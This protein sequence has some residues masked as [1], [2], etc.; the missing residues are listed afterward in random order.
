MFRFQHF[1][2]M[3][4]AHEGT[5]SGSSRLSGSLSL[6]HKYQLR[7]VDNLLPDWLTLDWNQQDLLS[8]NILLAMFE[9]FV[10]LEILHSEDEEIPKFDPQ[11]WRCRSQIGSNRYNFDNYEVQ[12]LYHELDEGNKKYVDPCFMIQ[13]CSWREWNRRARPSCYEI[14]ILEKQESTSTHQGPYMSGLPEGAWIN[15]GWKQWSHQQIGMLSWGVW[16]LSRCF[17]ELKLN[18]FGRSLDLFQELLY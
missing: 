15:C 4:R 9:W 3:I 13:L 18:R 12:K 2:R 7:R 11:I 16:K 10:V 6:S 17:L 1:R 8:Y 5:I 14:S